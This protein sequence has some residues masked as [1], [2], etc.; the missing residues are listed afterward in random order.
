[1]SIV[2]IN[3]LYFFKILLGHSFSMIFFKV[4]DLVNV[5]FELC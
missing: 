3:L 1:M 5:D 4:T 2:M